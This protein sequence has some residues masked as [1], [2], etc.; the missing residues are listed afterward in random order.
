MY[1]KGFAVFGLVLGGVIVCVLLI[2]F[3]RCD[4]NSCCTKRPSTSK[5]TKSRPAKTPKRTKRGGGNDE[6][7]QVL[8]APVDPRRKKRTSNKK[9]GVASEAEKE[10]DDW[11]LLESQMPTA[12]KPQA[13]KKVAAVKTKTVHKANDATLHSRPVL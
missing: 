10:Q 7:M 1:I 11:E 2:A 12:G 6:E 8:H 3:K 5:K 4:V 9:H 13:A